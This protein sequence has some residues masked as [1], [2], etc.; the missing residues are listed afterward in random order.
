MDPSDVQQTSS[1]NHEGKD[2]MIK[3]GGVD[4][5]RQPYEEIYPL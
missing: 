4:H 2:F 1:A 5:L 3:L